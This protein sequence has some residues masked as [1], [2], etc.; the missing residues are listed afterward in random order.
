MFK[1]KNDSSLSKKVRQRTFYPF[2]I[3]AAYKQN[4]RNYKESAWNYNRCKLNKKRLVSSCLTA[5]NLSIN[6]NLRVTPS[7]LK[8]RPD[9]ATK[10]TLPAKICLSAVIY[11]TLIWL[12]TE[13]RER[14]PERRTKRKQSH[15][16]PSL[17]V[18]HRLNLHRLVTIVRAPIS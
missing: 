10:L 6:L 4:N 2:S 8:Q 15:F 7:P 9:L 5:Q 14:G 17:S 16:L 12:A 13:T 11:L 1:Q 18:H 3:E